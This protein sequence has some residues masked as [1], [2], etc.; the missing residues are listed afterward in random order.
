LSNALLIID[1][2]TYTQN[3]EDLF[4]C[5]E[6]HLGS[7]SDA[8]NHKLCELFTILIAERWKI[9]TS[10]QIIANAET[11]FFKSFICTLRKIG[12]DTYCINTASIYKTSKTRVSV[13]YVPSRHK[14]RPSKYVYFLA[15]IINK[16][17]KVILDEIEPNK[18]YPFL[19]YASKVITYTSYHGVAKEGIDVIATKVVARLISKYK[20][21]RLCNLLTREAS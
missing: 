18:E 9:S 1:M 21:E 6:S 19:I 11:L 12:I 3:D 10:P 15:R 17:A 2:H 7:H 8:V 16:Y 4:L 5:V 13:S 20:L 14:K